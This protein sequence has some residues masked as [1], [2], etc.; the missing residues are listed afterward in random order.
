MKLNPERLPQHLAKGLAPV[1]FVSGDEPLLQ[2]ECCDAIRQEAR[3]QGYLERSIF[4]VEKGFNW[5]ALAVA[6]QSLSLFSSKQLLELRMPSPKPGDQGGK[7][8]SQ[9]AENPPPDT[10]LLICS[11]KL[12][13]ST[14][15]TR[16]YKALDAVGVM[17]PVW[18]IDRNVLPR[19]VNQRMQAKGL[20]PSRDA[21]QLLCDQVEGNLL[22]AAQEIEKLALLY[23]AGRIDEQQLMEA[24][25]NSSRFSVF[26]LVDAVLT[27]AEARIYR[28]LEGLRSEGVEPILVLWALTR[29]LRSLA[30]MAYA[31]DQGQKVEQV[32]AQHRVWERR[33][34]MII[35]A[36]KKQSL[37]RWQS[38][39]GQAADIDRVIK[40]VSLGKPWDEL[41]QLCLQMAGSQYLPRQAVENHYHAV[42]LGI[43]A[44]GH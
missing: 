8:L 36:L 28:I 35:K 9:Y 1:Y 26:H 18:P 24:V 33:K 43:G 15:R 12:E 40:G 10:M 6:A 20:H 29:E 3:Q 7:I 14:A 19:W 23:P 38:L 5:D 17:V 13:A 16:W 4:R 41:L 31:L 37:A 25:S 34:P 27:G 44:D 22:A 21:V 42:G 2:Q 32:V 30:N 39:L 11:G